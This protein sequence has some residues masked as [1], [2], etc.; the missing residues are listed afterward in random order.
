MVWAV[1]WCWL[2]ALGSQLVLAERFSVGIGRVDWAVSWYWAVGWCW[3][4][5]L[6]SQLVLAE[7]FSVGIGRV[8]W[9]VSWYWP[10]RLSYQL[11]LAK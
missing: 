11:V 7:R 3:P 9:A 10:S 5:A 1:S 6:G 8:D 2:S 4:S